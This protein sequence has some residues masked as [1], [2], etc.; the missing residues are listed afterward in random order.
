MK[1][2]PEKLIEY[3]EECVSEDYD[4]FTTSAEDATC[5]IIKPNLDKWYVVITWYEGEEDYSLINLTG[6]ALDRMIKFFK[7]DGLI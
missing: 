2:Y 1:Q 5:W 6:K 4:I 3:L 7:E